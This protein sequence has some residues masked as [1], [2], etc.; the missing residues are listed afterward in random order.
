MPTYEVKAPDGQKFRVNAPDGATEQDAIAYVQREIYGPKNVDMPSPTKGFGQRLSEGIAEIPRQ[1]GLT[2]RHGIEGGLGAIGMFT[3]PLARLAGVPTAEKTGSNLANMIGLPTPQT[4]IEKIAAEPTKLLAGSAGLLKGAQGLSKLPGMAGEIGGLLAANPAQQM[5]AATGAGLAGGYVKETGGDGLAQG[6]AA[7]AGGL[8]APTLVGAVKGI[9]QAMKSGVEF[10]APGLTQQNAPQQVDIV[11][12]GLLKDSG[13]SVK[14]VSASVLSSLRQDVASAMKT[15]GKLSPDALRRLAD[16]RLAGA[17]PTRAG[18]TL[19][20]ADVTRQKNAAKF[21]VNSADPKL[22]QLGQIENAN[23]RTLIEGLNTLGANTADD[24]IGGASKVMR[25]LS[26]LDSAATK[27]IDEAYAAAR[28]TGGRSAAI[29]QYAFTQKANNL[30][31]DA[32]LGGKLPSD[33]RNLLN[34]SATGEMPL[35]VDVAEQ[36]KTRI[37]GLQRSSSDAAERKALGLVRQALDDAPLLEGQGQ[38]A[39]D[40]FNKAR[41]L[42]RQYMSV[43][44]RVPALQAVR[45]GVEP[46]KFVNQFIIGSGKD[47]SVMNVAKLKHLIKDSP[48]AL[49]AVRGQLL[50]HLKDKALNGAADEV[51]NFGQSAFNKAIGAI[52]DRKL[53]LFFDKSELAQIK[54]IGRVASYEQ[55]QPRGSAVNNPNTAGTAMATMFEKLASSPLVGKIPMGPQ[56]TGNLSASLN[57]RRALNAPAA[58][59][60][61]QSAEQKAYP[62]LLPL[63]AETGLLGP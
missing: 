16:Y 24:A 49:S 4:K 57:A 25:S 62:Y 50:A 13:L 27:R 35:T 51:G 20:V 56:F 31:D 32:L 54:A 12:S 2:A 29:D 42:N 39:I 40:A 37:A 3:D 1:I 59:T 6:G 44:E 10:L 28:A 55:V 30:L 26:G 22:Q 53:K 8:A 23:N 19:D 58:V 34:K 15:G 18:L 7:L 45:D 33:V 43:V 36:L 5:Q 52:G 41:G 14:D 21:G 9:P 46:D 61:Q 38:P 11:I 48:E 17:V 60:H 47:A 63:M